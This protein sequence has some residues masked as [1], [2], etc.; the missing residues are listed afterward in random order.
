[1]GEG[2]RGSVGEPELATQG[3]QGVGGEV[4]LGDFAEAGE[5]EAGGGEAQPFEEGEEAAAFVDGVDLGPSGEGGAA[6]GG[7][8]GDEREEGGGLQE[9]ID[10]GGAVGG[11]DQGGEAAGLEKLDQFATGEG[12]VVEEVAPLGVVDEGGVGVEAAGGRVGVEAVPSLAFEGFEGELG[13]GGDA[14][15]EVAAFPDQLTREGG[16][17]GGAADPCGEGE[18]VSNHALIINRGVGH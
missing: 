4:G 7:V 10:Q 14:V 8:V 16:R 11:D 15:G 18:V 1:M 13:P 9:G 6:D 2:G 12:E 5:G 3:F 17:E